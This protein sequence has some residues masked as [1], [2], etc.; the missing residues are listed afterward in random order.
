MGNYQGSPEPIKKWAQLTP[1]EQA[2]KY[3]KYEPQG[4][5]FT[6]LTAEEQKAAGV[7]LDSKPN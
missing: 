7:R 2:A 4:K 6:D 5:K 1:A 3:A